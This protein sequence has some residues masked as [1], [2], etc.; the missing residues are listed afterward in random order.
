MPE[1]PFDITSPAAQDAKL[2]FL[3]F[4]TQLFR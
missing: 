3:Q 4:E 1:Y 2:N